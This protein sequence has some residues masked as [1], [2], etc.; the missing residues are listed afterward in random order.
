MAVKEHQLF[1]ELFETVK[2]WV[3]A[4]T[5]KRIEQEGYQVMFGPNKLS[6]E[7][8]PRQYYEYNSFLWCINLVSVFDRLENIRNMTR[9][10]L[11]RK[12]SEDKS[13]LLQKWLIYNYEHY[14]IAYQGILEVALLL[15]NAVFD[16]GNPTRECSYRTVINNTR[17]SGTNVGA[18]LKKLNETVQK[19]REGKNLLVHRGEQVKLPVPMSEVVPKIWTGC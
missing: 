6:F 3:F 15:T 17:I 13:A 8:S 1:K 18:I 19:H 5:K 2:P 10:T 12:K 9:R 14:A 7:F 4:E 11:H 16:M